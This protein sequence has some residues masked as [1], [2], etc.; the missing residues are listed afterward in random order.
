MPAP[1]HLYQ[2]LSDREV[3][4]DEEAI[5]ALDQTPQHVLGQ[6]DLLVE[7]GFL[8]LVRP[9]LFALVPVDERDLPPPADPYLVASKL[10]EPYMLS[11]RSALE[12]HE[13]AGEPGETTYVTTPEA[14]DAFEHRGHRFEPIEATRETIDH[15]AREVFVKDQPV[16]VTSR[17]WTVV[18]CLHRPELAG[19][20]LNVVEAL[21]RFRYVRV[22]QL[23]DALAM[24]GT[25]RVYNRAGFLLELYGDR[26]TLAEHHREALVASLSKEA[27]AFGT[28]VGEGRFVEA[29]N[30][31][32][33]EGVGVDRVG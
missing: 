1:P 8:D 23:V 30:L 31:W 27:D 5:E 4:T 28:S 19:G 26:W 2:V 18:D 17:E 10:T 14:F 22:G 25:A 20:A 11:H 7:R 13:V 33:P 9:G 21:G 24:L 15:A 3:F 16:N 12:V 32:V 29:W 6:L